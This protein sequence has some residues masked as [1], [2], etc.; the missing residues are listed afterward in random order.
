[1]GA[2]WA[3]VILARENFILNV[4]FYRFETLIFVFFREETKGL[5]SMDPPQEFQWE[6][7]RNRLI[8]IEF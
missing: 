3:S 7:Q 6:F 2:Y 8:L 1:M 5:L 4:D